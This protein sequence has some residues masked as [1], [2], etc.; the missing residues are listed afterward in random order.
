MHRGL[1]QGQSLNGIGPVRN[2]VWLD[3]LNRAECCGLQTVQMN[4]EC[5]AAY[6]T[7][8]PKEH[9]NSFDKNRA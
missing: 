7:M 4:G 1:V 9:F 8:Y 2:M 3:R 5:S 6:S